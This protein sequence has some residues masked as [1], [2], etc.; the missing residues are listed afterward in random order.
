MAAASLH[1]PR[2]RIGPIAP[3]LASRTAFFRAVGDQSARGLGRLSFT[4]GKKSC[5]WW[6]K[7]ILYWAESAPASPALICRDSDAWQAGGEKRQMPRV[8][9][10]HLLWS[11]E[12]PCRIGADEKTRTF[13][14]VKEQRPQRCASTNSA[15]SALIRLR[16]RVCSEAPPRREGGIYAFA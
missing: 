1:S 15:T 4:R 13:T 14:P 11:I 5:L 9:A 12:N 16:W 6:R 7:V 2:R 3:L 10:F 8:G